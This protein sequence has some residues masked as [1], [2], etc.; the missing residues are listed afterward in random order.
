MLS[1]NLQNTN[2]MRK[3]SKYNLNLKTKEPRAGANPDT[4]SDSHIETKKK[5]KIYYYLQQLNLFTVHVELLTIV[6][7]QSSTN[8][9]ENCNKPLISVV[10]ITV[11][12]DSSQLLET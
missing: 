1:F 11:E 4:T 2:K 8:F 3:E 7:M 10:F 5:R 6:M 9:I 12:T